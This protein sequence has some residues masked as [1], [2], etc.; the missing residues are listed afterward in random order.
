MNNSHIEKAFKW[1]NKY[2][3]D[4]LSE[5]EFNAKVKEV[6]SELANNPNHKLYDI[7]PEKF[8]TA[9]SFAN[10]IERNVEIYQA[11][12]YAIEKQNNFFDMNSIRNFDRSLANVGAKLWF[13]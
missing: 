10:L 6:A 13:E 11:T 12:N 2:L 7:N 9:I 3:S 8:S 5:T 1:C 4:T